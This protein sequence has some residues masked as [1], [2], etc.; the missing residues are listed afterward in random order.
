M[1]VSRGSLKLTT[2]HLHVTL[3]VK[4]PPNSGP[5]TLAIA[6]VPATTPLKIARF[7]KGTD[8]AIMMK[9]PQKMPAP[10]RPEIARPMIKAIDVGAAPQTAL[11]TSKMTIEDKNTHF[12]DSKV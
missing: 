5:I 2:H 6:K 10:P 7:D 12:V 8:S 1:G 9:A 11:P 3:V 4:A